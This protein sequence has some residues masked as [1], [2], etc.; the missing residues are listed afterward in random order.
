MCHHLR[1]SEHGQHRQH[2]TRTPPTTRVLCHIRACGSRSPAAVS[3]VGVRFL[4]HPAPAGGLHRPPG[5]PTDGRADPN[6]VVVL[7]MSKPRPGRAP[8][9]PGDG[10]AL[11]A[12]TIFRPAPAALPRPV[13][14]AR[15]EHPICGGHL[16]EASSGVY[17]R[18]PI[19]PRRLAAPP[20][21]ESPTAS[22]GLLLARGP[23]M[24]REPLRLFP[25]LRTPQ[26]P[27]RTPRR[28]Q[29]TRIGPGTTPSRSTSAEPPPASPY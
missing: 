27:R 5:R 19:T 22:A 18:S 15:L 4:G 10:G 7:H 11:P 26:L 28:R 25:G 17:S 23:P 29:A 1:S 20:E 9:N 14:A 12:G 2:S 3:A 24:E 8:L 6:G 16:H 21:P 13:A